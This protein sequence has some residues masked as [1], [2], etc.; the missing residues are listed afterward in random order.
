MS[1]LR[2]MLRNLLHR[3]FLSLLTILSVTATVGFILLLSMSKAGVEE[4]AENGYG[5]FDLVIGAAGSETQLVLNTFYHVGAPTGNIAGEAWEAVSKHQGIDQAFPMTT[6]DYFNEFPIVG[7][8]AGYF[9]TRYGDRALSDGILYRQTGEVVVG[10][11]VAETLGLHVGDTF[12]GAH[13]LV[14]DLHHEEEHEGEDGHAGEEQDAHEQFRYTITGILPKLSTP[15]DR[16]VFTTVDYAWAVHG[17]E[18]G[19]REITAVLVKPKSLLSGQELRDALE[20]KAGIQVVYTSKAVADVVNLVDRGS[21]LIEIV[22]LL[23]VMLAA[24][25]ILLSLVAAAGERTKDAGLLRLL[26]KSKGYIMASMLGEGLA[27]TATGLLLGYL[28]GHITAY[29][30]QEA[31]FN[32]AGIQIDPFQVT[33]DHAAIA[34][35]ALVTGLAASLLPAFRMYRMDALTLFKA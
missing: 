7:I 2:Y 10:A 18:G 9:M 21:E 32:Y 3:K 35:G 12:T 8:D 24:V 27:L 26:G 16:A 5:P 13:G 29:F 14:G 25:T 30:L 11:H 33:G 20:D 6:G 17:E 1:L 19:H 31:V 15:D 4:G 23:C 22:T 34:V 28:A